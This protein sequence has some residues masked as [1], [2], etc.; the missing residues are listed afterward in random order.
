[1]ER[2]NDA[3]RGGAARP[4]AL[5][6]NVG[7]EIDHPDVDFDSNVGPLAD[8]ASLANAGDERWERSGA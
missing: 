2:Q 6:R 7:V 4:G 8:E 3:A 1:M 5:D